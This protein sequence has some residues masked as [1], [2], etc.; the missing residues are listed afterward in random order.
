[1]SNNHRQITPYWFMRLFGAKSASFQLDES[2]LTLHASTGERYVVLTE[3]LANESVYHQGLFF[4]QLILQTDKGTIRFGGL[5]KR[6]AVQLYDC[7]RQ[8]WLTHLAPVI[9]KT[10]HQLQLILDRRYLRT[11]HIPKVQSFAQ[12]AVDKFHIVPAGDWLG[13]VDLRPFRFVFEVANWSADDVE[14]HRQCYVQ[15]LKDKHANYFDSVES[16]PLT[17]RQCEACIIDEDNNLVLAGAGMGKTSTMIGRAGFLLKSKQAK[18]AQILMLAYARKASKEMQERIDLRLGDCGITV[19]TFHK[20]GKEI[21]ARVEG[22]QPSLTPLV[23]D[24]KALAWQVNQWFELHLQDESYQKKVLDYFK[25]HLYPEANPFDFKSE[26]EYYEYLQANDIHTLKQDPRT[27]MGEKVKSWG[28][29]LVAN[30]LFKLGI[31]YRYEAE[32]EHVTRD[33]TYRQYQPDFYLPDY[34]IYLEYY[35]IDKDG[36]TA[37]Y[38][39]REQYHKGMQWKRELHKQNQTLLVEAYHHQLVNGTLFE[40]LDRQ[41]AKAGVENNPLPPEAVLETLKEFGAI[42]AFATLLANLL[43]RYQANCYEEG[44]VEAAIKAAANPAQVRAALDLLLPIVADYTDLLAKND[45]IDFDDMIG[46]AIR[47]VRSGQF[48]SPWHYLLVDEFQDISDPRARLIQSLK[49]SGDN[50]SLFCVGDDW[51]AIYRF[52]GSDLKFTTDFE[53]NFGATKITAL[54]LTFRFNN[55]IAD[56]ASRFILKNPIQL[57]KA[58]K[59]HSTVSKPAVSLI[60]ADNRSRREG[61]HDSRLLSVLTRISIISEEGSSV[62]LLGRYGF[63]LPKPKELRDLNNQYTTLNISAFTVHSSKGK[64]ADYIVMLGL[65]SG[66]HGFP[67]KKVTDPLLEALLP[68]IE[69]YPHAEERRLFYVAITRAKQRSYLISDMAVASE[70]VIELLDDEYPIEL[71][72]FETSLSQKLFQL[73]HCVKCKSGSLVAKASSYGKFYG[74]NNF[75]RCKHIESGCSSCGMAMT[76]LDRF[77]V[78]INPDCDTWVP[79]CPQCD[80]EMVQRKGRRGLFWGCKNFKG[81]EDLTCRHTEDTIV[82]DQNRV[83]LES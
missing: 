15:R 73:I 51:Q 20:L 61:S 18:P 26:G 67:S 66:K 79:T 82:F 60:R 32:Y 34:G 16:N 10:A 41:L 76:R 8:Y 30:Y 6:D 42:S 28:E 2:S 62:F 31:E 59:T 11:S 81:N 43:S 12:R 77:K 36:N 45:H 58:L 70:F 40:H 33:L 63:N 71:E 27:L 65:E 49:D 22:A 14:Q 46:K 78:C 74:C 39:D 4:S 56:V 83:E 64:E 38:I 37:P 1:M 72:E 69:R 54:D 44:Q 55:S 7:F 57:K 75:P 68:K 50:C 21:I 5:P 9:D 24:D 35:G 3:S 23:E 13:S 29:C 80:A 52:A 17:P 25:Y 53:S 19:N 48:K 47:Y